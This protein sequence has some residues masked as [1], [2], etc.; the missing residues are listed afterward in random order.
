[1]VEGGKIVEEG[2]GEVIEMKLGWGVKK[3]GGKGG[4]GGMVGNI[5]VMVDIRREVVKGVN[6]GVRV[7]RGV[8]WDNE[9]VMI[10]EVGEELEEWG[11]EG[12][13]MEGRRGREM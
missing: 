11:M 6:V 12:V 4:G 10:R 8:G 9:K 5:G 3:V 2:D 13:S 1:M 7:K